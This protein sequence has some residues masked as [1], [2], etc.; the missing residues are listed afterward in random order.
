LAEELTKRKEQEKMYTEA[1]DTIQK[2]VDTLSQDN[3][4][5]KDKLSKLGNFK[6][7]SK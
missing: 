1:L 3:R 5:L 7:S 2:D 4:S 6:I